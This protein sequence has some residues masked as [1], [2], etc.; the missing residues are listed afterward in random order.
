MFLHPVRST[1][2]VLN[3]G[4]F[5]QGNINIL[6]SMLG[7]ERY[8]FNKKRA[9]THYVELMFLRPVGFV[10]HVV[11]SGASEAQNVEALFFMHG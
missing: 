9:R 4:A 1:G 7:W 2:H 5:G 10:G 6:F 3:S 8:G 11:Y